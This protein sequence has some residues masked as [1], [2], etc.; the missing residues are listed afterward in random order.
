MEY[1]N[2]ISE[3]IL[4]EKRIKFEILELM[5]EHKV[6][7]IEFDEFNMPLT[8]VSYGKFGNVKEGFVSK[9]ISPNLDIKMEDE[10]YT[11]DTVVS[12][13]EIYDAMWRH[14]NG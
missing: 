7:S 10:W 13:A 4:L 3:Q 12:Y 2:F 8:I 11:E 6:T 5:A 9:I 1:I 14:F